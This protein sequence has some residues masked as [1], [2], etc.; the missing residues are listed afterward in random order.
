MPP[1]TVIAL[2]WLFVAFVVVVVVALSDLR[3]YLATYVDV[4]LPTNDP[5]ETWLSAALPILAAINLD[6]DVDLPSQDITLPIGAWACMDGPS[7]VFV[8]RGRAEAR[9]YR[10]DIGRPLSIVRT[11]SP[12]LA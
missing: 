7:I 3:S 4:D 2:A 5:I 11:V 10:A 12:R 1:C 8:C 6:A 9:R